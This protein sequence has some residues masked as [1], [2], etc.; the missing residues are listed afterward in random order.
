MLGRELSAAAVAAGDP[1]SRFVRMAQATRAEIRQHIFQ[2][3]I[4]FPTERQLRSRLLLKSSQS[5]TAIRRSP[6]K[7][8][9]IPDGP[10][11]H[12]AAL[13]PVHTERGWP[14]L[15]IRSAARV[16]SR[17]WCLDD[18]ERIFVP[19][20][21]AKFSGGCFRRIPYI[22][23]CF[24]VEDGEPGISVAKRTCNILIF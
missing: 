24:T 4:R 19:R 6:R 20:Q 12:S 1:S 11:D 18:S 2:A 22:E 9:M 13:L 16:L 5:T 14:R 21:R 8:R 3:L 10:T 17:H 15:C 7:H 23:R